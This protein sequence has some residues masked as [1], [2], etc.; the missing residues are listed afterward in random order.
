MSHDISIFL[1][2]NIFD[3]LA[4]APWQSSLAK[5]FQEKTP[6]AAAKESRK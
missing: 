5:T 6:K 3:Y 4:T 1:L 2:K